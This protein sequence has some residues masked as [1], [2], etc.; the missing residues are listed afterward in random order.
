MAEVQ[1]ISRLRAWR[2]ERGLTLQ[3]VA[4]LT[5]LSES[6]VSRAER[7]ERRF[8][9]MTKVLIAR[10]LGVDVADIFEVEEIV[11]EVASS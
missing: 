3:E 1:P 2:T 10:R 6:M 5:G 9:P 8:N 7:A 11:E 4:D